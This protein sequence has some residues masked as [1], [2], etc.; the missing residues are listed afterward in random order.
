[1]IRDTVLHFG[2]THKEYQFVAKR[3]AAYYSLKHDSVEKSETSWRKVITPK[4]KR[5]A[6]VFIWNGSQGRTPLAKDYCESHNVPHAFFEWGMLPQDTTFFIDPKGFCGDSIL[7]KDLSWV[8]QADV[9]AL[10]AKRTELQRKH[11][12]S[13][14]GDI[15]VPLQIFDDT[16]ILYHTPYDTMQDFVEYLKT[17]FPVDRLLIRPHPKGGANYENMGVRIDYPRTPFIESVAKCHSVVGLTSTSLLEAA[18]LGK[19]V[20]ALGNCAL[21]SNPLD[22]DLVAAG[23]LALCVNR[24]SGDAVEILKRFGIHPKYDPSHTKTELRIAG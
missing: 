6:F 24:K 12:L 14:N 23:A 7:C 18:V 3:F 8:T 22:P 13:D 17:I 10:G 21:R 5:A 4:L 15:L 16:Q 19:P 11:P 20:M 9:D 2:S 1:M